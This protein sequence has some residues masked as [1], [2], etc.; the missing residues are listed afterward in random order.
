VEKS[1][2]IKKLISTQSRD[3]HATTPFDFFFA[4]YFFI[5]SRFFFLLRLHKSFRA[6][7]FMLILLVRRDKPAVC[8]RMGVPYG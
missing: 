1:G 4:T 3:F 2:A 5:A 8:L 6:F 7:C